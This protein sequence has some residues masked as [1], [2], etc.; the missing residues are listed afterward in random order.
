MH[1]PTFLHG[2]RVALL[3]G[4]LTLVPLPGRNRLH[5]ASA[6]TNAALPFIK[7]IEAFEA[8]DRTNRPAPGG[9][10]FVG[11]S[12]IRLWKTLAQDFPEHPVINRGFGGS[13]IIDSV[14]RA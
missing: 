6:V 14:T 13:Q 4:L 8:S 7:E 3:I 2:V 12:S 5:A 1:S 9:L 10:L 11:S